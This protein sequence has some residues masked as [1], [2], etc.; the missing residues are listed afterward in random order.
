MIDK[1]PDKTVLS[2]INS[3]LLT[4]CTSGILWGAAKLTNI[5]NRLS[6]LE[7]AFG[8]RVSESAEI[9]NTQ[10]DHTKSLADVVLRLSRLE[11]IA[12]EKIKIK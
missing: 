12:N 11:Y 10:E 7:T 4:I 1:T 9:K 5:D 8:I 6:S 3:I 2:R